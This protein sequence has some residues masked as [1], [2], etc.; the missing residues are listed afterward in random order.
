MKRQMIGVMLSAALL[1]GCATDRERTQ[2]E[3]TGAGAL[4]GAGLGAAIGAL[5][6]GGRGAAIGAGAGAAAGALGGYAL[7]THVANQKE[8]FA[9]QE[10]YL[11]AVIASAQ[12]TNEQTQQYNAA[13]RNDINA[14][15]RETTSLVQQYNRKV[16]AKVALQKEEQR[17][18]AKISEA[19]KQLQKVGRE[20]DIQRQVL[21][22]ERGQAPEHLKRLQTQ[23]TELERNKAELE[24]HINRLASL[25]TRVAV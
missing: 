15:D 23:V 4:I 11:D 1:A 8:K 2:A 14:L 16:L 5:A 7:G 6:G 3:G 10:D 9:R 18:A 19:Q 13:L 20:L 25:K 24:Q 12:Q 21:A 17:L 22:Q